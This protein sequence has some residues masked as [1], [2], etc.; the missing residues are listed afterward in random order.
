MSSLS[1][2]VKHGVPDGWTTTGILDLV[3]IANGQADPRN[4]S[5]RDLPLIAPDHIES[6]T[7]RLLKRESARNQRAISGK[8]IVRPG[9]VVYSK[10]RPY[11][12]KAILCDFEALCSADM[13][14]LA[15]RPGVTS[16]FILHTVLS[17]DFTTFATSVSARSGIPKLNR[18]ELSEYLVSTPPPGEQLA[19]SAALDDADLLI[20]ALTRLITKQE[21]IRRG[22]MQ[23][24]LTG[25]N[26][27]PGF[28]GAW[29][30]YKLSELGTFLKGRGIR[31]DDVRPS[32]IACIR[33]GELYT[34]LSRSS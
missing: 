18:A 34:R 22:V 25:K 24:L 12:Q 14:P 15:P 2:R 30:T 31:R 29:A 28:T 23:Q 20:D 8:Y 3:S 10:I 4:P 7:G 13:Y 32:G 11:L 17:A 33:Y 21:A 6:G 27:L 1:N 26:R 16:A 19:M 5:Y 9:N